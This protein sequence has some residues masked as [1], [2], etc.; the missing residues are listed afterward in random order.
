MKHDYKKD[1]QLNLRDSQ[2]VC[3]SKLFHH[4]ESCLEF[5]ESKANN[6]KQGILVLLM[7]S[8]KV[9]F[10]NPALSK[11][12]GYSPDEIIEFSNEQ[13]ISLIHPD[14]RNNALQFAKRASNNLANPFNRPVRIHSR[15]GAERLVTINAGPV[16]YYDKP[17]TL[18]TIID[19]SEWKL[20][21]NEL[22]EDQSQKDEILRNIA[23]STPMGMHM[24]E[25]Q[26]D[27]RLVFIGAN[28]AANELLNLDHDQ[29][30]GMTIEEAFPSSIGTELPDQYRRIA[31]EGNKWSTE[32]IEYVDDK[33]Q[34]AFEVHA[35]QTSPGRMV[36]S[37][38]DITSRKRAYEELQLSEKSHRTV[39]ESMRDFVF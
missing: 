26:S 15:D 6:L 25:L 1:S 39:V 16:S 14:D 10:S 24:Y 11:I 23:D 13:I 17:A 38:L 27:N 9:V 12:V 31:V 3:S 21:S 20:D 22:V 32:Q 8:C 4:I 35:F 37:F 5:N 18:Y 19:I 34:G 30:I 36:A 2:V 7:D 28:R 29:F 33:I